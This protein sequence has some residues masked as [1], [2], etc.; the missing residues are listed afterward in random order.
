MK[1]HRNTI[2]I[3]ALVGLTVLF[4]GRILRGYPRLAAWAGLEGP[5]TT[6]GRQ[7]AIWYIPHPDDETL[8]MGGS[9]YQSVRQNE[10]AIMVLLTR[11]G[12]SVAIHHVNSILESRQIDPLNKDDFM[13]AR[14]REFMLAV[15][16]LGVTGDNVYVHDYPDGALTYEDARDVVLSLSEKYPQAIHH[17]ISWHDDHPDH[18]S[19]G[20]A[21]RDLAA[22]GYLRDAFFYTKPKF[23]EQGTALTLTPAQRAHK[24]AALDAYGIWEP[25]NGYYAIGQSS[26][27]ALFKEIIEL[28]YE[29]Y[30]R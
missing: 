2:I 27:T 10:A 28:P 20:T 30:H 7:V 5:A 18:I 21:V 11:G 3:L 1:L 16:R 6:A 17:T 19:I 14:V 13:Q 15:N 24:K 12:E 8:F 25:E 9:I 29:Y 22:E 23:A 26:V 4:S